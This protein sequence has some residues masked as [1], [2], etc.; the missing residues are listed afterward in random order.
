MPRHARGCLIHLAHVVFQR[1]ALISAV[2]CCDTMDTPISSDVAQQLRLLLFSPFHRINS[3][4]MQWGHRICSN[5]CISPDMCLD[6]TALVIQ[7]QVSLISM[8]LL[9]FCIHLPCRHAGILMLTHLLLFLSQAT[10][11]GFSLKTSSAIVVGF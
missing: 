9:L 6:W 1:Q 11:N 8:F 3:Q 4:L 5:P 10:A 7:L 2:I